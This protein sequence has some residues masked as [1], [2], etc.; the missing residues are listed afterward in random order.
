M[1][2]AFVI[3]LAV[4]AACASAGQNGNTPID[5]PDPPV[6]GQ[7]AH[8]DDGAVV[9]HDALPPL[10]GPLPPDAFV[11]PVDA[12]VMPDAAGG[13]VCLDNTN[14]LVA[15]QCCYFFTC[16]AGIGLG[17]NICVPN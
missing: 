12:S 17:S 15:G 3:A 9:H 10:D 5:A 4:A 1:K 13:G 8:H 16:E 7:V 11:P 14:C 6:D 2:R